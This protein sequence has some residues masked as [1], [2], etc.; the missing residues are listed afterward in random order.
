MAWGGDSAGQSGS[1]RRPGGR[2]RWL[3]HNRVA[4]DWFEVT[5]GLEG[6]S[7]GLSMVAL[8]TDEKLTVAACGGGRGGRCPGRGA[9]RRLGEAHG[10]ERSSTAGAS[11]K[12]PRGTIGSKTAWLRW[13]Q[14]VAAA[15]RG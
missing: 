1:V 2:R 4:G 14:D 3:E 8:A 13:C 12:L 11:G 7:P 15:A 10:G 6:G 5:D 9:V